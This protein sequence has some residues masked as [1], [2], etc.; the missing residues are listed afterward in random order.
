M[1]V[2][3]TIL[4]LISFISWGHFFQT[5]VEKRL[6]RLA[7][8]SHIFLKTHY[9]A[10][11]VLH[12]ILIVSSKLFTNTD[13]SSRQ[14]IVAAPVKLGIKINT[15]LLDKYLIYILTFFEIVVRQYHTTSSN[16]ATSVLYSIG[17]N[18]RIKILC[19]FWGKSNYF[20][21]MGYPKIKCRSVRNCT[22]LIPCTNVNYVCDC[23][24][25]CI[26]FNI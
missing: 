15:S 19:T 12:L 14:I 20:G 26:K 24:D 22:L 4:A 11:S 21:H 16:G 13:F 17:K 1:K 5:W 9:S 3:T 8:A 7:I 2:E 6:C 23:K 18:Y 10:L 25:H